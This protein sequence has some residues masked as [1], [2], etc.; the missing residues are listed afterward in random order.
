MRINI[1]ILVDNLS[2]KAIENLQKKFDIT[3][4]IEKAIK[5]EVQD[6]M[7]ELVLEIERYYEPKEK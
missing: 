7:D 3:F 1:G 5:K 4:S 6:R 2:E